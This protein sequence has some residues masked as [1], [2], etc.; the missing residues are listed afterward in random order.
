MTHGHPYTASCGNSSSSRTNRSRRVNSVRFTNPIVFFFGSDL[1]T[2]AI[3][4]I[5]TSV[6]TLPAARPNVGGLP[7]QP[8]FSSAAT[9]DLIGKCIIVVITYEDHAHRLVRKSNTTAGLS[10]C[11][12]PI[13]LGEQR[14][15]NG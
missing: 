14:P 7:G 3:S 9:E 8:M 5:R 4:S 2:H 12:R 6:T 10:A 15:S 13:V 11:H 1:S